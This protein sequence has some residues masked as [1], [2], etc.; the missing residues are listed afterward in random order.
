MNSI[1]ARDGWL[2]GKT[3]NLSYPEGMRLGDFADS[4]MPPALRQYVCAQLNG[5]PLADWENH[6]PKPDEH[7]LLYVVP[8]SG[9]DDGG[10]SPILSVVAIAIAVAAPYVSPYLYGGAF[11]YWV[12]AS[13]VMNALTRA[14]IKPPQQQKAVSWDVSSNPFLAFSGIGNRMEPWGNVPR[15]YGRMRV[16]PKLLVQPEQRVSGGRTFYYLAFDFGYGPLRITN[17]KIGETLLTNYQDVTTYIHYNFTKNSSLMYFGNP[18]NTAN[19]NQEILPE[20]G[21]SPTQST[22]INTHQA[23]VSLAFPRG[24]YRIDPNSGTLGG[25]TVAL[26]IDARPV[27]VPAASWVDINSLAYRKTSGKLSESSALAPHTFSLPLSK[28]QSNGIWYTGILA[29]ATS[30]TLTSTNAITAPVLDQWQIGNTVWISGN[31]ALTDEIAIPA[32][33]TGFVGGNHARPIISWDAS[34]A[35][36]NSYA[37]ESQVPTSPTTLLSLQLRTHTLSGGFIYHYFSSGAT[38]LTDPFSQDLQFHF[39]SPGQYEI[40]IQN[41]TLI[42]NS[43]WV[44]D[45]YWSTLVSYSNETNYVF[46]PEAPHTVVEM[47]IRATNQLSGMIDNYNAI[48]ESFLPIWNGTD[49]EEPVYN[50]A[51]RTWNMNPTRNPAWIYLDVLRGSANKTPVSDD[52]LDLDAFLA[53]AEACELPAPNDPDNPSFNCDLIIASETTVRE[54]LQTIAATGRAATARKDSKFSIILDSFESTPVQL[55]TPKNSTN[56]TASINYIRV[57]HGLK[58]SFI[59]E[60]NGHNSSEVI[61]Y[62]DGFD[63]DN[64]T[65]FEELTMPGSTRYNQVW[66][67]GRYY[68]A[69]TILQRER[70]RATMDYEHLVCQR[71]DLVL[72]AHDVLKAGGLPR[73]INQVIPDVAGDILV[74][75]EAIT[76]AS[77]IRY[78]ASNDL[79]SVSQIGDNEI[80]LPIDVDP[81]AIG[82]LIEYGVSEEIRAPFI[83]EE[84]VPGE[85]L[86]ANLTLVEFRP[87]I[88]DAITQAIP[89]RIPRPGAGGAFVISSV[90]NL[91]ATQRPYYSEGLL[92]SEISL[93]W[94]SPSEGIPSYYVVYQMIGDVPIF[95][96]MTAANDYTNALTV[97]VSGLI[98]SGNFT[99]GVE[100]VIDRVGAGP[101]QTVVVNVSPDIVPPPDISG[102]GCNAQTGTL[103]LFWDRV[104]AQDVH[105][106]EIRYSSDAVDGAWNIASLLN[107]QIPPNAT[108]T[109]VPLR[110]GIY[111]IKA[112]DGAGNYSV[113]AANT[114][115]Q[116]DDLEYVEQFL[117]LD[118]APFDDG[119]YE[120]VNIDLPGQLRLDEGAEIGWYYPDPADFGISLAAQSKMR[121]YAS[122]AGS[123]VSFDSTL[124]SDWFTPLANAVP[125]APDIEV[126]SNAIDAQIDFRWRPTVSDPWSAWTRLYVADVTAIDVEFRVMLRSRSLIYTPSVTAAGIRADWLERTETRLDIAI[127]IGGD[128]VDFDFAFAEIPVVSITL[129][130]ASPGDY[131][132]ISNVDRFGFDIEIFDSTN[133]SIAGQVDYAARGY[134]KEY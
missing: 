84:I 63:E 134:G 25:Y 39:E 129:E 15:V 61:V 71:G 109:V 19:V 75:D 76:G 34:E 98:E 26:K 48:A 133:T 62:N 122:V 118:F 91:S 36:L 127:G 18:I 82:D 131:Y 99:F 85:N 8:Q 113:N 6:V 116:I 128:H 92:Y 103:F 125:L 30:L 72:V 35:R 58:I 57:P 105:H 22:D 42:R 4:A 11:T 5:E 32:T 28:W 50:M 21:N 126:G 2:K 73:R 12:G 101:I 93:Q 56:F 117:T 46:R 81:P 49:W 94:Q 124:D 87:E 78:R 16:F 88:Q 38:P 110:P 70:V 120:D 89:P 90:M 7:I 106:L 95:V 119:T 40:R 55:V 66:R 51:T 27:T 80:R 65:Q 130:G 33:I 96:G 115:V 111:F 114:V 86:S 10:K 79:I 47:R 104:V 69:A 43:Y 112:V 53:W 24:L 64:S 29:G 107:D 121:L 100:P 132:V 68:L 17:Q 3:R 74:L 52:Q 102:F 1:V 9:G 44:D 20:F 41:A 23:N 97:N 67:L 77:V 123:V 45:I 14:L 59:D 54:T 13:V 108:D 31:T 37:Q 83:V 60:D